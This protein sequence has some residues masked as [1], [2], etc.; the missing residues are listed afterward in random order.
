[1]KSPRRCDNL[2]ALDGAAMATFEQELATYARKL[3]ELTAQ[4]GKFV[5]A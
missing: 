4:S 5:V 2:A 1:M 3:P